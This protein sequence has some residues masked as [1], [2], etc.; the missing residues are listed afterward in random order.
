MLHITPTGA[1]DVLHASAGLYCWVAH[2]CG[3]SASLADA[4]PSLGV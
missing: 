1:L 4:P 3:G 2:V